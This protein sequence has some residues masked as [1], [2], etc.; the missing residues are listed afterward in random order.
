MNQTHILFPA[1]A[2]RAIVKNLISP[3][4]LLIALVSCSTQPAVSTS[5][6]PSIY[7]TATPTEP[8]GVANT[9]DFRTF[10][11]DEI[12][13]VT[14]CPREVCIRWFVGGGTGTSQDQI[15]VEQ[16]VVWD[17]NASQDR[18]MLI[19]EAVIYSHPHE[20][21]GYEIA[22][23]NGADVVGP[24]SWNFMHYFPGQWLDLSE[25]I[26]VSGFDTGVF[27]PALIRYYQTEAGQ[28]SLP[29]AVFPGAMYFVPAYFDQAG[30]NYPPQ[31]YGEKY[32]MPD[33]SEV[34]WNWET[35]TAIA[36]LLT[37]DINGLNSTE[38]GFDRDNIVRV[39]YSPQW[40]Q[41]NSIAAFYDGAARIYTGDSTGNYAS[42]IPAGWKEAWQWYYN[43]MYGEQPFMA[44]GP[45][46][47][48]LEFGEGNMFNA[49]KAAMGLTQSWYTCC[50]DDFRDAGLE[51]QLGIQPMGADGVVNGRLDADSFLILKSSKHPAEAFQ[52]LRYLL[53]TGADKLLPAYGGMPAIASEIEAYFATTKGADYPFVTDSSWNV[54]IQ[55][56]AYPDIPSVEQYRP[57][58]KE[59]QAREEAFL[60]LMNDTPPDQ[61]DF[62]AEFQKLVDDLNVIYN[63]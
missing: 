41:P 54:F 27:D 40:Q 24:I 63:K 34:D 2:W 51:F 3:G 19:L 36:K 48:A 11:M 55:S 29:F 31:T 56:L 9:S 18:I 26:A 33:G 50:L 10:Y 35:V 7:A 37:I 5:V 57:H 13:Q 59:A 28:I 14:E 8:V 43:G 39:G 47:N 1:A 52:V 15:A 17:F 60:K 32:I 6:P 23:D 58:W 42:T 44:T 53:T 30:L 45:L 21:L 4:L 16:E 46:S 20:M 61:F 49:G 62:E 12:P 22:H 38:A 25:Q